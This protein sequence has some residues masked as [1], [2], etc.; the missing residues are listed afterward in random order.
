MATDCKIDPS[1]EN[2]CQTA[3]FAVI[4][5]CFTKEMFETQPPTQKIRS[6]NTGYEY[7][8]SSKVLCEENPK[9]KK[10][11]VPEELKVNRV[12][13]TYKEDTLVSKIG[14]QCRNENVECAVKTVCKKT[15]KRKI[16][17][18]EQRP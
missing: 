2:R 11:I 12:S 13:L 5:S 6:V 4:K 10:L 17:V 9:R 8:V 18:Y 14:S 1:L 15:S 3:A 7:V 16:L